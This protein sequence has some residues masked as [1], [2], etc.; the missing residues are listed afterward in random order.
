[1][2]PVT[3]VSPIIKARSWEICFLMTSSLQTMLSHYKTIHMLTEV[4]IISKVLR[5]KY[6]AI[7]HTSLV[8]LS[9]H[10]FGWRWCLGCIHKERKGISVRPAH[11]TA[12]IWIGRNKVP[13]Q[14]LQCYSYLLFRIR[15]IQSSINM[16]EMLSFIFLLNQ[17]STLKGIHVNTTRS[18]FEWG[19]SKFC[20]N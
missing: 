3:E 7:Q 12:Y 15:Q 1:M 19:H 2:G 17:P 16:L 4:L 5:G 10:L 6:A 11:M 18:C 8:D 14:Q 9:L 13:W 20:G